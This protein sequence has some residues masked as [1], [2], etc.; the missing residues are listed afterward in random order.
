MR[1][2]GAIEAASL[3]GRIWRCIGGEE[4]IASGAG[5]EERSIEEGLQPLGE[6]AREEYNPRGLSPPG[7]GVEF[8]GRAC[9][10]G[11]DI[12]IPRFRVPFTRAFF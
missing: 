8:P 11:G 12:P 2:E 5:R 6:A 9:L 4:G 10:A 3:L 1:L 7:G